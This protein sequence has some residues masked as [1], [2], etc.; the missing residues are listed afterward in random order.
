MKVRHACCPIFC[1]FLK[2]EE[3]LSFVLVYHIVCEHRQV[4]LMEEEGVTAWTHLDLFRY[5]L[6]TNM[7]ANKALILISVLLI[8]VTE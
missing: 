4:L 7:I 8:K 6:A 3:P 2:L 1:T 5:L